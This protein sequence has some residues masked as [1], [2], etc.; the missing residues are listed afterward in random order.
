M[1]ERNA[2]VSRNA[3]RR[4]NAGDDFERNA[5]VGQSFGLFAAATEDERIAAFQPDDVAAAL[6]AFDKQ[7]A[8][9]FLRER[10]FGFLL[11]D[12]DA[13]GGRGREIEKF[14][15]GQVIVEDAIGAVR[16]GAS[17]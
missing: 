3:K 15:I 4:S 10:V 12:V 14:G 6:A 5:G 11:A 2:R 8:D 7:R 9:L 1:G 16:E 17:L 13:L